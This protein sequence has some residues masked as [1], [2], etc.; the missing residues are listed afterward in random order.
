MH[1]FAQI[2]YFLLK[3]GQINDLPSSNYVEYC[4]LQI[5]KVLLHVRDRSDQNLLELLLTG[6]CRY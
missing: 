2:Q 3:R 6:T 1:I 5:C 4:I